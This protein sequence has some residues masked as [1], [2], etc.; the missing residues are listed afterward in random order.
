[1]GNTNRFVPADTL[2]LGEGQYYP[3]DPCVTRLNGNVAVIGTSGAGKTRSVV[4]PNII[5]ATGSYVISDPKGTLYTTFK[6]Y[7]ESQ[8]YEVLEM[9]F[10]H[11]E[12]S[13]GY[14][15]VTRCKTTTDVRKL[16][17]MITYELNVRDG[18]R[19]SH[20]D[21]FW[22]SATEILLVSLIGGMLEGLVPPKARNLTTL[23]MLIREA[24]RPADG[25][26]V[27]PTKMRMEAL[28]KSK[29]GNSWSADRY[30]EYESAP[31][32]THATINITTLA[33][34]A[35]FD[36]V[37][38]R[39]MLEKDGF[40][41]RSIGEKKTALFVKVSDT[42]RSMD[43]LVNLFY[44]QLMN[45]LCTLADE[46]Y[47]GKL[48][49]PVRFILDDFATNARIGGFENM[50]AN[51]RSRG[52]SVMIM[53]QSEAQLNAV[54]KDYA[55]VIIDCCDSYVYMGGSDPVQAKAVADRIDKRPAT[56]L[57]MPIGKSWICR[58]GQ[59]PVF[60]DNFDIE[61]FMLEKGVEPLKPKKKRPT[62]VLDLSDIIM[63]G[64]PDN[65]TVTD[66][67]ELA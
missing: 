27:S 28:R 66:E 23:S 8:G 53:L 1:M 46:T 24:K 6:P 13:C 2:I 7:L 39:K 67:M 26:R 15:P 56:V 55:P 54:Y 35:T 57:H 60:C 22:D 37:E 34:L 21:P 41:S 4:M 45:E 9:D 33:K 50:V 43:L 25:I 18:N 16:A 29:N 19:G 65:L 58:R 36:T 52:I 17:H 3:L 5:Q 48:P 51:I 47:N 59:D 20:E 14:N 12:K 63:P 40:S 64:M 38:T 61:S 31:D 42:D 10:I 11:P 49:V 30:D 62:K 32:R 44:T